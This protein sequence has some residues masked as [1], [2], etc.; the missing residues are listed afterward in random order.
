[1]SFFK[2]LFKENIYEIDQKFFITYVIAIFGTICNNPD[3]LF[4]N[5]NI[6]KY[7]KKN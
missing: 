2:I 7:L 3:F 1:M 4:K 5:S 6:L